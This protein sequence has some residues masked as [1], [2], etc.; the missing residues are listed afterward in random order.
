MP[1]MRLSPSQLDK[2][3]TV[4]LNAW[5]YILPWYLNG[6]PE[7]ILVSLYLGVLRGLRTVYV[8]RPLISR[9]DQARQAQQYN[10]FQALLGT[11]KLYMIGTTVMV[12]N[13]EVT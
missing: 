4:Q 12:E 9:E 2:I 8:E 13:T 5:E 7:I 10:E 6:K 11:L 1:I 3:Q